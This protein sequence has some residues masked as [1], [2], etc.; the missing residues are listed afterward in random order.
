MSKRP[1]RAGD[2][3]E[4][5]SASEILATLDPHGKLGGVPF[6]PEMLAFI[7]RRFVVHARAEKLCDTIHGTGSR[8]MEDTVILGDLRCD[9]CA[10]GGCEAD[11]RLFFKEAWLRRVDLDEPQ[12][13]PRP[14][15]DRAALADLLSRNT[16][17]VVETEGKAET[18]YVCQATE[19]FRASR[20]LRVWDPRAY[21]RE[22][23][24]GNVPFSRFVRVTA[25]AFVQVTL[26]KLGLMKEAVPVPG[27]RDKPVVDPPLHLQPGDWVQVKSRDEIAETLT[28]KGR[29]RGLWFDREMLPYCGGT[30]RVRRLIQRFVND[31]TGKMI[32]MKTASVTLEGAVCSGDLSHGR[33]FCPRAIYP[34]WR[35]TWLRRVDEVSAGEKTCA[36][37]QACAR[38]N[39]RAGAGAVSRTAETQP[40]PAQESTTL[41]A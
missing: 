36:G 4:V 2:H 40:R 18:L 29:N 6:M 27:T 39:A 14:D 30:F 25:R 24:C 15:R 37:G 38:E 11:C 13:L 3:V 31:Q 8:R 9:G 41:R 1:L 26:R 22:F 34:Y 23:T 32:E 10:H 7:G 21:V 19:A 20:R 17:R 28:P 12:P 5:R 35:E 33:W 16:T